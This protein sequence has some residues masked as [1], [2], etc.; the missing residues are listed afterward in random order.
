MSTPVEEQRVDPLIGQTLSGRYQLTRKIGEGGMGFVYEA[1]HTVIGKTVAVKILREKYID[2]PT[3]AQRLVQEARL[4]SSI[5]NEHI[6]D[7]T[8]SGRTDDGRTY[9]VMELLDGES[10]ADLLRRDGALPEAR[11]VEIARQ[12]ASALGAAHAR[13]IIHRDVKPEN[14]FLVRQRDGRDFVKVVDF[15]ISTTLRDSREG[16]QVTPDGPTDMGRLTSTGVVMGTPFYMSP[17]QGRGDDDIDHRIDVYALGVIMYECLTAEVPFRGTN[18]LGI[19]SK[20]LT[21]EPAHPRSLRPELRISEAAERV[22][23]KAMSKVRDDRYPSMEALDADLQRVLAGEGVDAPAPTTAHDPRTPTSR[24]WMFA[25]AAMVL[26]GAGALFWAARNSGPG[27]QAIVPKAADDSPK[28]L[29]PTPPPKTVVLRIETDP[30]GAEIRQG[31]RVFGVAP[32]PVVVPRSQTEVHLTFHLDGY[33]TASADPVP[34]TD[35][36]TVRVKLTPKSKT[37]PLKGKPVKPVSV[38]TDG[39]APTKPGGETLP[40]P[41]K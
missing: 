10:L 21:A 29:E 19:I 26:V 3:V 18:Y 6:I 23:L 2:R 24:A 33:E 7:I 8:D 30:P 17:E 5:R 39:P 37:K 20:V 40:N 35:D 1:Q 41:Y 16:S 25:A 22:V 34:A 14:V 4:A 32:Y 28:P 12:I 38:E 15:G 11:T 9:V 31:D 27:P 36:Q 13:G